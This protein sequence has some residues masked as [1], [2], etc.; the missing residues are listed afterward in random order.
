M[1]CCRRLYIKAKPP[2][3][4]YTH[5]HIHIH[6]YTYTHTTQL[7]DPPTLVQAG[8]AHPQGHEPDGAAGCVTK[9]KNKSHAQANPSPFIQQHTRT[10]SATQS[11]TQQISQSIQ[12]THTRYG[13]RRR[14]GGQRSNKINQINSSNPHPQPISPHTTHRRGPGGEGRAG[15]LRALRRGHRCVVDSV[16][17]AS[18]LVSMCDGVRD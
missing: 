8:Q 5:I 13:D 1:W 6:I 10:E 14:P 11:T 15:P 17:C 4:I 12:S 16:Q 9:S 7:E 18:V 2:D 3:R